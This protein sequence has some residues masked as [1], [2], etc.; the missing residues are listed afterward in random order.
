MEYSWFVFFAPLILIHIHI[1]IN[2][3]SYLDKSGTSAKRALKHCIDDLFKWAETRISLP[4]LEE[5][6]DSQ[7]GE[8]RRRINTLFP[9]CLFF[10]VDGNFSFLLIPF[11]FLR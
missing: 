1:H 6:I 5:W 2:T 3:Y 9:N 7:S 4:T 11:I 8:S 10:Y